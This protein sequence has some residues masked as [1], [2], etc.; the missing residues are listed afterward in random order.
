MYSMLCSVDGRLV[1]R[2]IEPLA[3]ADVRNNAWQSAGNSGLCY[4]PS[5]VCQRFRCQRSCRRCRRR[6]R[7]ADATARPPARRVD[8]LARQCQQVAER[9]QS[10]VLLPLGC[11]WQLGGRALGSGMESL[12]ITG[13][14]AHAANV[15]NK[16]IGVLRESRSRGGPSG[17]SDTC[18]FCLRGDEQRPGL[19]VRRKGDRRRETL[20]PPAYV[21]NKQLRLSKRRARPAALAEQTQKY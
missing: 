19:Q 7:R 12:S 2:P 3:L 9:R 16:V 6:R 21:R 13:A 20:R 18:C 4:C 11:R 1:K 14:S 10:A 17:I 5:W 15:K 8:E